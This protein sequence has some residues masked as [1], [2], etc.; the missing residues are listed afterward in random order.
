[1]QHISMEFVPSCSKDVFLGTHFVNE[2]KDLLL[3]MAHSI[4]KEVKTVTIFEPNNIRIMLH[5]FLDLL[6]DTILYCL[7]ESLVE[8]RILL[9]SGVEV[10]YLLADTV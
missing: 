8:T 7:E 10:R 5:H 4:E 2:A 1:M 9:L 6:N 3:P